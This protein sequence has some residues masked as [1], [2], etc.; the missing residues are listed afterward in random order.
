MVRRKA[1][2]ETGNARQGSRGI[3]ACDLILASSGIF[4]TDVGTADSSAG[5][6]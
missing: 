3:S 1:K 5:D 4:A 6:A 2:F